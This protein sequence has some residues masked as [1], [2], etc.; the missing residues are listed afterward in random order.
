MLHKE[1][2]MAGNL[3]D[4]IAKLEKSYGKGIVMKLGD[5]PDTALDVIDSG[6]LSLNKALGINGYPKGRIVELFGKESSGKTTLCIHA[7]A[8]CQKQGGVAC[9]I[10]AEH[11]FD[12]AYAK[13][14]GVNIDELLISQP[15]NGE[16]A[17]EVLDHIV[18]S[19]DVSL[20]IVD[21]VAALVP[22]AELEGEMG[23]SKM[24]LHARLMS[25]AMRKLTGSIHNTNTCVI[26]INQVR[27]KIGVMFGNPFV[28]TGG[29]GL[30]FA[31]SIRLEISK[32]TPLKDGEDV[33][34]NKTIVKVVKNKVAPPF[35][36][37]EFDIIYG[38]GIDN[39]GEVI[40]LA[41]EQGIIQ[42]KGAWFKYEND[43]ISQG[44]AGLITL[45][46]DNHELLEII[47]SKIVF[48]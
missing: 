44:R 46:N 16:E 18:S 6:S 2:N 45:L 7:I 19:G 21:S 11:A 12:P 9:I 3:K 32:S 34:G 42:Q 13:N 38:K 40:D 23:D 26:F 29:N 30:K 36:K 17:L 15:S 48:I 20:V 8:N 37:A 41:L 28:T 1:I 10:D 14:L 25:Q 35:K 22:K 43:N 24:G 27:E 4:V 33:Y 47:K 39:V 31:A 5:K